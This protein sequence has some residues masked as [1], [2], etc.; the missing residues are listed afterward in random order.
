[1]QLLVVWGINWTTP[2]ILE[3]SEATAIYESIQWGNNDVYLVGIVTKAF[4]CNC[5]FDF[6]CRCEVIT[7]RAVTMEMFNKA[8]VTTNP[9]CLFV[10]NP[11]QK[12]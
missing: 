4:L 2:F 5:I 7:S 3:Q 10:C 1:M 11:T 9:L 6:S 12:L 8:I